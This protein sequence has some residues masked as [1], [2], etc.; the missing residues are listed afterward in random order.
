MDEGTGGAQPLINR[1]EMRDRVEHA[2][3]TEK[4]MM[5]LGW[6]VLFLAVTSLAVAVGLWLHGDLTLEQA[7]AA[8]FGVIISGILSGAAGLLVRRQRGPWRVPAGAGDGTGEARTSDGDVRRWAGAG[9]GRRHP[10]RPVVRK[11]LRSPSLARRRGRLRSPS[12]TARRAR[13]R[14]RSPGPDGAAGE[15]AVRLP[16]R[17]LGGRPGGREAGRA[18]PEV[19]RPPVSPTWPPPA[20]GSGAARAESRRR[21][22]HRSVAGRARPRG[23]R[24]CGR[25]RPPAAPP[26]RRRTARRRRPGRPTAPTKSLARTPS[27]AHTGMPAA[28]ASRAASMLR[29]L[30]WLTGTAQTT[31]RSA[32]R[33]SSRFSACASSPTGGERRLHGHVQAELAAGLLVGVE[34]VED[35]GGDFV[36][37]VHQ[38]AHEAGAGAAAADQVHAAAA[39]AAQPRR[40]RQVRAAGVPVQVRAHAV[41]GLDDLGPQHVVGRPERRHLPVAEHQQ[42]VEVVQR[43]VEVV[44]DAEHR[45][46]VGV[47][48][49]EQVEQAELVRDVERRGRLVEQQERRLLHERLREHHE[50]LL[51]AGELREPAARQL[52]DPE[53]RQR[54]LGVAAARGVLAA[55][56]ARPS[57]RPRAR[58]GRSRGRSAAARARPRAPCPCACTRASACP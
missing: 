15:A 51:A 37:G 52:G 38:L 5:R 29:A 8:I 31:T 17:V 16:G 56:V 12:R 35:A 25:G 7:L 3:A 58:R 44:Q 21:G 24:R 32:A 4:F 50:L 48:L 39:L 49:L 45:E 57:R 53:A 9:A 2:V 14:S 42:L 13:L 43:Q 36:P 22:R 46:A 41:H 19:A 11:R 55:A 18:R 28:S 27:S 23:R 47:E 40:E 33:I 30:P 1:A 54:L 20:A 34:G 26:R 10:P 6:I